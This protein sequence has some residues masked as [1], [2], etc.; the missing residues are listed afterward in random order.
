YEYGGLAGRDAGAGD[1][2]RVHEAGAHVPAD[3][4]PTDDLPHHL[5]QAAGIDQAADGG[6]GGGGGG[7]PRQLPDHAH[8]VPHAEAEDV[9]D[10]EVLPPR[11]DR[12]P[13]RFGLVRAPGEEA[14]VDR[15]DGGARED[16]E[17]ERTAELGL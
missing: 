2:E 8:D 15:P 9:A 10:L 3:L 6:V 14:G 12:A 11:A 13:L 7:A 16:L 4:G 1:G 17:G 5:P